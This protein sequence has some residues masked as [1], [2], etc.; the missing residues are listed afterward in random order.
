[1]QPKAQV[2]FGIDHLLNPDSSSESLSGE[3]LA[4]LKRLRI[5]LV[6]N[7]AAT[8]ARFPAPLMPTRL[9]LQQAGVNLVALFSPEHG[10]AAN[11]AEGISVANQ[12]DPLT[13][14]PV[15]SLYGAT[16]RPTPQQLSTIDL[17]LFDIPD[18]GARFYTYIWTLSH[19]LEACAAAQLPLW[20]LDRPN[21]LSGNLAHI[22]GPM[23]NEEQI[24]SFVGR[25]SIPVRHSLTI[26]E[27]AR[28]WNAERGLQ[29]D[30]TVIPVQ[31]WQ[32]ADSWPATRLPFIPPSPNMPTYET[33]LLYMGLCLFEGTNLSE[34]RGTAT[35]FR[36]I[37]APWLDSVGLTVAFN[38]LALPGIRARAVHFT[39]HASKYRGQ[40]CQGVM[41]HLLDAELARPVAAGLHLLTLIRHWHPQNFA[42][43][44]T[45]TPTQA[46]HFDCLIGQ[47][48]IRRALDQPKNENKMAITAWTAAADWANRSAPFLLYP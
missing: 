22:E 28:L 24:S 35:P 2:L 10:L 8:T 43:L 41:L 9:A 21:P 5:G 27:L 19:L 40:L 12:H 25:W 17:L 48:E 14:L 1:M 46:Q 42:W 15:Y 13:G 26:G 33:A 11:A 18:I 4:Q 44:P 20:V 30:L 31:N 29:V 36:L 37:G 38:G 39:P 23:L 34:G 6:T 3:K 16:Q 45:P 47:L 32:R 7:D